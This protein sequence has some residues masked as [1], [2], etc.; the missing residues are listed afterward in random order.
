MFSFHKNVYGYVK[1]IDYWKSL[2]IDSLDKTQ[3]ILKDFWILFSYHSGVIENTNIKYLDVKEIFD[4]RRVINYTGDLLTLYEI[5][6]L[7]ISFDYMLNKAIDKEP[8]TEELIKK[9]HKLLTSGTYDERRYVVNEERPG[10]YKK[11]DYVT[12]KNEV[13]SL[14]VDVSNDMRNL[15]EEVSGIE[16][17]SDEDVLVLVAYVHNMIEHIHPFADGNGRLG[18]LLINYLLLIN[19]LPPLIIFN[20]DKSLYYECLQKFDESDNL[21]STVEFLKYE[22]EKTWEKVIDKY[23]A[24]N[25]NNHNKLRMFLWFSNKKAMQVFMLTSLM[26]YALALWFIQLK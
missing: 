10:E 13:G 16:L 17:K 1:S 5:D 11:H 24:E 8:L 15:I 18:R 2:E 14:P 20:D 23:K 3:D 6:N 26:A 12:G 9:F 4:S 7:R 25:N 19:G 22:M 21:S